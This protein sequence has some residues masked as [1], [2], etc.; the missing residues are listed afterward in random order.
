MGFAEAE[1]DMSGKAGE[2]SWGHNRALCF[3]WVRIHSGFT[4]KLEPGRV[5]SERALGICSEPATGVG[6]PRRGAA[7]KRTSWESENSLTLLLCVS[8]EPHVCLGS[9]PRELTGDAGRW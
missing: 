2:V 6:G 3:R 7:A 9:Y 1:W 4:E 8:P 5:G